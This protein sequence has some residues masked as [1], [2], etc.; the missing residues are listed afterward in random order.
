ML[1]G[2]GVAPAD[3]WYASMKPA[4]PPIVSPAHID[5]I[6]MTDGVPVLEH[7]SPEGYRIRH[8]IC[9]R[10]ALTSG[11]HNCSKGCTSAI[12]TQVN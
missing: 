4:M 10:A 11:T 5:G 12:L 8:K 3:C 6:L 1:L 2:A 9:I 7:S